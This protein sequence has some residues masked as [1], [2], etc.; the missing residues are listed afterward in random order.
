VIKPP[1]DPVSRV[2]TIGELETVL[3][4][5]KWAEWVISI[6]LASPVPR[7]VKCNGVEYIVKK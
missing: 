1:P 3:R 2:V 6:L 4:R 5:A 7:V